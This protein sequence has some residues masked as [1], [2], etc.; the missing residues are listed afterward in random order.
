MAITNA[1]VVQSGTNLTLSFNYD[2]ADR[3]VLVHHTGHLS[4]DPDAAGPIA[5]VN[6]D[7]PY[8]QPD[9][10]PSP[11]VVVDPERAWTLKS[12]DASARLATF[13][14]VV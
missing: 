11:L 14:S 3:A 7:Y 13:T 9:P 10:T 2:I 4:V 8:D 1:A 6:V 5:P 12:D